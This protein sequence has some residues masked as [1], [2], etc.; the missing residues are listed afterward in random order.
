M[1]HIIIGVFLI[2]HGAVHI[3]YVAMARSLVPGEADNIWN[4]QSWLLTRTLGDQITMTLATIVFPVTTLVFLV[5]GGAL[6]AQQEWFATWAVAGAILSIA[7][8]VG[9]WD[10][11]PDHPIEKGLLGIIIDVGILVSVLYFEWPSI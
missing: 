5:A 1:L 2:L 9:F 3:W 7:A 10:G 6:V 11:K 4:G 8:I